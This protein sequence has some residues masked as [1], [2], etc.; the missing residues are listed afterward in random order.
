MSA[1]TQRVADQIRR[2]IAVLIQMELNDPRIGMV[3]VTAVKVSRDLS[4]AKIYVT[5]LNSLADSG[6]VNSS[7]LSA[8]GQLDKL[9]IEE[10]LKALNKASGYLRSLLAK[11]LTL[12]S[13][14]KLRFHY[15][16]SVERGRHLSELIDNALAA[17]RDLHS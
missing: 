10:N 8:P 11:R 13:V 12:R 5:V 4:Y 1:R 3:S 15:D 9:E 2:E 14:P 7:T 6:A 16:G 17:D